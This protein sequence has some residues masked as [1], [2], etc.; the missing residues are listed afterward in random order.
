M[1]SPKTARLIPEFERYL[2]ASHFLQLRFLFQQKGEQDLHSRVA[3]SLLTYSDLIPIDRAFYSAGQALKA[4]GRETFAFAILNKFLDMY[5]AIEDETELEPLTDGNLE[6]MDLPEVNDLVLPRSNFLKPA[7]KDHLRDWLLALS[8][9]KGTS[10]QLNTISCRQCSSKV[11]EHTRTCPSCKTVQ[12]ET[13]ILSGES[14][15]GSEQVHTC[16]SCRKKAKRQ[17]FEKFRLI[18]LHCAWCDS[19]TE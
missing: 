9:Q 2:E 12:G 13:C 5:E 4:A 11:E 15:R 14:I 17:H 7:E 1:A 8:A 18:S 6:G 16:G 10:L 19:L 3:T